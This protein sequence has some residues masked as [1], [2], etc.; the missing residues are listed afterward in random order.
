MVL[1]FVSE[2]VYTDNIKFYPN[3]PWII[4]SPLQP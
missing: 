4:I 1:Y 3:L 2:S